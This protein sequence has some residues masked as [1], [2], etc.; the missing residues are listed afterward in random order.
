MKPRVKFEIKSPLRQYVE[1]RKSVESEGTTVKEA[2]YSLL[3]SYPKLREQ[4]FASTNSLNDFVNIFVNGEDIRS[5]SG[6]D[7]ALKENDLLII[8]PAIAGG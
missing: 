1:N 3:D 6:L 5:Q 8:M 2:L 7:T 4:L